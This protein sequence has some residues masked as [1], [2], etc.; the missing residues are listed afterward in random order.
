MNKYSHI[1]KKF[2]KIVYD[3]EFAA[4]RI[5]RDKSIH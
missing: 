4:L 2:I 5:N 3:C 1:K